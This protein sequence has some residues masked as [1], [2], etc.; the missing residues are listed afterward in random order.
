MAFDSGVAG[1]RRLAEEERPALCRTSGPEL[2]WIDPPRSEIPS[3]RFLREG[4]KLLGEIREIRELGCCTYLS[5][6]SRLF[7]AHPDPTRKICQSFLHGK[8][9]LFRGTFSRTMG[10]KFSP[11]KSCKISPPPYL[12]NIY[13]YIY[14]RPLKF[15]WSLSRLERVSERR[16]FCLVTSE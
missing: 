2:I 15:L 10:G 9:S 7:R 14:K 12:E 16:T 13:I 11:W 1:S 4:K 8:K 5:P 3:Q 6:A